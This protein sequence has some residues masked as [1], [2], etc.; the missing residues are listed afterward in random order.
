MVRHDGGHPHWDDLPANSRLQLFQM[1][2]E[3]EL[4]HFPT[5]TTSELITIVQWRLSPTNAEPSP[6]VS[7]VFSTL[8][9]RRRVTNPYIWLRLLLGLLVGV[10]VVRATSPH[11]YCSPG[12]TIGKCLPCPSRARCVKGRAICPAADFL[13]AVGCRPRRLAGDYQRA[14]RAAKHVAR[15]DG[16]C[17]APRAHMGLIQFSRLFPHASLA[18]YDIEPGFNIRVENEC[19][20]STAPEYWAGCRLLGAVEANGDVVGPVLVGI[21]VAIAWL[22]HTRRQRR[23][24][25][26]ARE[27]ARYALKILS[28]TDHGVY[29][30]DIKA[31]LR[32]QNPKVD[33]L[34]KHII[35][36]IEHDAHVLVGCHGARHEVY[37]KWICSPARP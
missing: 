11:S 30:Y 8:R 6:E 25:E 21:T 14:F 16:D 7:S 22:M 33:R 32:A 13:S 3:L 36:F 18:L 27:L 26:A 12:R 19:V 15:H 4:P 37:W 34:W 9:H 10:F 5:A 1:L 2:E 28:T 24:V 29:I 20:Y 31:Q 23:N 35:K 17:I